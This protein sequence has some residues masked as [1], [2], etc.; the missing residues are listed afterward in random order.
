[1]RVFRE[2]ID[3]QIILPEKYKEVE[4]AE[5]AGDDDMDDDVED[6][7]DDETSKRPLPPRMMNDFGPASRQLVFYFEC[8]GGLGA[9]S[10]LSL[11]ILGAYVP[12]AISEQM[13]FCP[14]Y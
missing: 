3:G 4:A 11:N 9:H 6:E 2:V 5:L 13:G 12:V 7:E 10:F 1:M 14:R 8:F